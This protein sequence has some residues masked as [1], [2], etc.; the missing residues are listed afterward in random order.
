MEKAFTIFSN[1]TVIV[2]K[3]CAVGI[4]F[5]GITKTVGETM[6]KVSDTALAKMKEVQ[7]II[8]CL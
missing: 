8:G 7:K 6:V 5:F 3:V 1:G 2:Y 4:A